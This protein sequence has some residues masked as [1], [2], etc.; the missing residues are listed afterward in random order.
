MVVVGMVA[1][2]RVVVESLCCYDVVLVLDSAV[3]SLWVYAVA[4]FSGFVRV[5][6]TVA[7]GS[8]VLKLAVV[9][10]TCV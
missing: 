3:G 7:F 8:A 4:Q 10:R 5:P 6:W 1:V 2:G 9:S